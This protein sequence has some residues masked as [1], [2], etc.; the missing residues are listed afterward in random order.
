VTGLELKLEDKVAI[1][2]MDEGENRLNLKMCDAWLAMLEK[3]EKETTALTLV[4][5]SAHEKI[6]SNGFDREWVKLRQA[7]GDTESVRQ[8]L[9]RDLE[10][11]RRM[12]L[13]PL[14]TV[15]A[16]NGHVF[17]G[18]AIFSCCFDFRFMRSDRGYFCIPAID[19]GY[20]I[21]SGT[22]ALLRQAMP[23][24]MFEEALLT[25]R[26]F[27][28]DEAAANHAV[29]AAYPNEVLMGKVMAF[30]GTLNKGRTIIGQMKQVLNG[31]II[32]ILDEVDLPVVSK[33]HFQV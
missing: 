30:A 25:G 26:R 24:H 31:K 4:V 19:L 29:T 23:M 6:W 15:A 21:V 10:M 16:I 17:G 20:P 12:L 28:G 8:F 2:T 27:T 3:V 7:A 14:I 18:G 32:N 13:Y 9:I 5:K 22:C 1:V 11:R 33:G